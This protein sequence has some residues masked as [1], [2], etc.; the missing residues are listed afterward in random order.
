VA[1]VNSSGVLVQNNVAL[2]ISGHAFSMALGTETGNTMRRNLAIGA[3]PCPLMA[4][5]LLV[6]V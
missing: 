3:C 4:L 1:L 2:R 5:A 6:A